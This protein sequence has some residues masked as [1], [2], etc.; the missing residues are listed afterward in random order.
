M[1]SLSARVAVAAVVFVLLAEALIFFPSL[2][3]HRINWLEE[4]LAAAQIAALARE[5][6]VGE[7]FSDALAEELLSNAGVLTVA[8]RRADLRELVLSVPERP[9]VD[10]FIELEE[11][12]LFR[13]IAGAAST[14]FARTERV[15]YVIGEPRL[16]GGEQIEFAVSETP[17]REAMLRYA[18][19][20]LWL[21]LIISFVTAGLLALVLYVWLVRP[22]RR[23]THSMI[24]F[25]D[26]PFDA[27]SVIIP[28]ADE[29]EIAVAERELARMQSD[30]RA[31]LQQQARLAALGTAV[32]KI[33]HDLRNILASAQLLADRLSASADPTVQRVAP[34]L[35]GAIDRAVNLAANTLKY[36]KVEEPPPQPRR[37]NLHSLAE[38]VASTAGLA[39]AA[40][41]TWRNTIEPDFEVVAD[42]DY[43][44]RILLN[45][46]RNAA[47]AMET[48]EMPEKA[49]VIAARRGDGEIIIDV[50]DTG[51]GLPGAARNRLFQAFAGSVRKGGSGLGLAISR[52][53][54]QAHGGDLALVKSE[55]GETVFR[56]TLPQPGTAEAPA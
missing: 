48:G 12:N 4:R 1:G 45:L 54:A 37:F 26:A 25:R 34:K 40:G 44:F 20:I 41:V 31:S 42:Q 32:S 7:E 27:S 52:E 35:L 6:T 3:N 55:P 18:W 47:Q 51:P 38:D 36:G 17:L 2:G 24:A 15:L 5:A 16:G 9:T 46:A 23:I 49:I 10:V 53:L 28:A 30:V 11:Q 13:R 39:G 22:M 33:N 19:N 43:L 29:G 21:S 14:L 8:L 56:L 50:S